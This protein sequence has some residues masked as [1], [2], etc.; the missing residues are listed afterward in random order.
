MR[1]TQIN[2]SSTLLAVAL[3]VCFGACASTASAQTGTE[4]GIG[5]GHLSTRD[6]DV[7]GDGWDSTTVDF[8]FATPLSPHDPHW[9]VDVLMTVGRRH[10]RDRRI[11]EGTYGVLLKRSRSAVGGFS[12]FVTC[13]VLG[14]YRETV[15]P[16]WSDSQGAPLLLPAF[17]AGARQQINSRVAI[18]G[19]VQGIF[20]LVYPY[21]VRA[22]AGLAIRIGGE[23]P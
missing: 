2:W 15:A 1:H 6:F 18:Q 5:I 11:T 3:I 23:R 17:G 8:R 19:D 7:K 4:I 21:G 22:T 9:S 14:T 16:T 12:P 10:E 13:G 20:L